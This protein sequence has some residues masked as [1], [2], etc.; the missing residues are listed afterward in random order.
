MA[1]GKYRDRVRN[2]DMEEKTMQEQEAETAAKAADK[3][4]TTVGM[5]TSKALG[6]DDSASRLVELDFAEQEA[7]RSAGMEEKTYGIWGPIWRVMD[8]YNA[9][10]VPHAV[11]RKKYLWLLL[12]TGW[13]GGHRYYEKRWVLAILYTALFW[14]ALPL[15]MCLIDALIV[16]PMKPD[17]NGNITLR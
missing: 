16:I 10:R 12:L 5:D 15:A 8:W 7:R 3:Q 9:R 13:I 4:P 11:N 2:T 14:T 1:K 6:V 17:E